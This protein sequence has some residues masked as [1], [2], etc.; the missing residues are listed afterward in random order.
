MM[1]L[2]YAECRIEA[3]HAK[4]RYAKCRYAECHG[5]RLTPVRRQGVFSIFSFLVVELNKLERLPLA[6]SLN[7]I[8]VFMSKSR[9]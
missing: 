4:F 8:L 6:S 1:S 5:A 7:V 2:V 9:A 3:L